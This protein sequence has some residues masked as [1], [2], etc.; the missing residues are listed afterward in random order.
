MNC[1]FCGKKTR[2]YKTW[3][4]WDSRSSHYSCWKRNEQD[5]ILKTMMDDFIVD[6]KRKELLKD[7]TQEPQCAQSL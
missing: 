4:E 6:K 2:Y 5:K 1:D 7:A 3:K